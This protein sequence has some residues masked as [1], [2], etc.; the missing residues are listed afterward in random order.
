[1]AV[2][3]GGHVGYG[4]C[5]TVFYTANVAALTETVDLSTTPCPPA[6]VPTP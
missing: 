4:F 6:S 3:N 5:R 1:M 2:T